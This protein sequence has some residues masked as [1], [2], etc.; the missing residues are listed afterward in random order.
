MSLPTAPSELQDHL[1]GM[2]IFWSTNGCVFPD[3]STY[4]PDL[5]GHFLFE[6]CAAQSENGF[7]QML[8]SQFFLV[9]KA[10]CSSDVKPEQ[11]KYIEARSLAQ[12]VYSQWNVCEAAATLTIKRPFEFITREP[13]LCKT[14]CLGD[15]RVGPIC[16]LLIA[17][18]VRYEEAVHHTGGYTSVFDKFSFP[19]SQ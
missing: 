13:G 17:A 9:S 10:L 12:L 2:K 7:T 4:T 8:C 1:E 5:N 14:K 18:V 11:R 15:S 19:E 16:K 3:E 6:P